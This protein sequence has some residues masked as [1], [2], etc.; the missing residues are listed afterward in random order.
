M[1]IKLKKKVVQIVENKV[2]TFEN[3]VTCQYTLTNG[4]V[5]EFKFYRDKFPLLVYIPDEVDLDSLQF[6]SYHK[7]FK[8][9][10]IKTEQDIIDFEPKIVHLY[11]L[12]DGN[13]RDYNGNYVNVMYPLYD[14]YYQFVER[15]DLE[16]I[17][18]VAEFLKNH[19]EFDVIG[20]ID[21]RDVPYYNA[22]NFDEEEEGFD[23]KC[24]RLWIRFKNPETMKL[25]ERE[26]KAHDG[27]RPYFS[28]SDYID[29]IAK[30]FRTKYPELARQW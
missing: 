5:T 27:K 9:I 21:I 19:E 20:D 26:I 14:A 4:N 2:G 15:N 23:E 12:Y 7:H 1:K 11:N 6:N 29:K 24:L 28:W 22:R 16:N 17:K 3:D 18:I 8:D 25:Y 30:E 10:K 13:L